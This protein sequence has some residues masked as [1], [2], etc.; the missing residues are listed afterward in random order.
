MR[1]SVIIITR[2]EAPV[3]AACL[4]SLPVHDEV[5]VVDSGSTDGTQAICRSLG[6]R[7]IEAD[8]PGFGPQ[9]QRA[10]DAASGRWVLS[11]D[12]D[13]RLD[14]ALR[15]A[16]EARLDADDRGEEPRDGF[17]MRV[18]SRFA[19]Q[20][21]H[22][23]D[24]RRRKLLLFRRHAGRFPPALVHE[25]VR[26]EGKAGSLPGWVLHDSIIDW[27][28]AMAKADLY[29]RL[30]VDRTRARGRVGRVWGL[31][32]GS[33]TFLR[34]YLLRLGFLDGYNGLRLAAANAWGTYLRY[35]MAA[36]P[37][38]RQPLAQK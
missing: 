35:A 13:E 8:W 23:G 7:V 22:F 32:H 19:G 12:A 38:P 2:N 29:A 36:R 1:L 16:I 24:W 31:L 17:F 4:R 28:D 34:G 26:I 6:A 20:Y 25:R 14:H 10:L 37:A 21:L 18:K 33:W 27:R 5:I 3:I 9:K 30:S 11:I 15:A